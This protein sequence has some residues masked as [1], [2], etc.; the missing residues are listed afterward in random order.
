MRA[1]RSFFY[2]LGLSAFPAFPGRQSS[3]QRGVGDVFFAPINAA[4]LAEIL[5]RTARLTKERSENR[6]IWLIAAFVILAQVGKYDRR[7]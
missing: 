3:E 2:T 1:F 4:I 6:V 5:A 7:G